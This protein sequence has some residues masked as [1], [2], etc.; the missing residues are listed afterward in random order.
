MPRERESGLVALS[1]LHDL[2]VLWFIHE[3]CCLV[4]DF[5]MCYALFSLSS[6]SSN[7]IVLFNVPYYWNFHSVVGFIIYG[8][9]INQY[10]RGNANKKQQSSA[11]H[12][13]TRTSHEMARENIYQSRVQ[14]S[15]TK[16][17]MP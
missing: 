16:A 15:Y 5:A 10:C 7:I 9:N 14:R 1:S 3:Q 6:C 4:L 17:N 2:L 8:H 12:N 13:S 11:L